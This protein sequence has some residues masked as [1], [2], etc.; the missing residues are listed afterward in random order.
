M[1]LYVSAGFL[2]FVCLCV[3]ALSAHLSCAWKETLESSKQNVAAHAGDVWLTLPVFT[4][5]QEH[6]LQTS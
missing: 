5:I 3:F 4:I 6:N 1:W 2:K